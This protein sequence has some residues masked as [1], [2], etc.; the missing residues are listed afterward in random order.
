[1]GKC[2]NCS[3]LLPPEFL[4]PTEDKL[5]KKCIF[6]TKGSDTIEY[7]SETE[8]KQ[9]KTTK[10]EIIREY[11]EFLNEISSMPHVSDI[12]DIIK[13]KGRGIVLV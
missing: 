3:S 6:C 2:V 10:A 11:I 4:E 5:A 8:N 1:M 7:F 9:V 12:L 13:E